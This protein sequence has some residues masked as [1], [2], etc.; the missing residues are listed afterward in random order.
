MH[1]C[2]TPSSHRSAPAGAPLRRLSFAHRPGDNSLS[3]EPGVPIYIDD[4]YHGRPQG[5]VM[6]LLDIERVEVLRGPQ[7]TL[8]GKNTLG[9]AVVILASRR[10]RHGFRRRTGGRA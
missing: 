10:D 6:D 1:S 2:R 8:F 9:G 3:F 4:V 5:A 7:G